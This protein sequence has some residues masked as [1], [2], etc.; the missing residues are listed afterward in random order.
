[1][2]D[3][4]CFLNIGRIYP[5][6]DGR[7]RHWGRDVL[8]M[9]RSQNNTRTLTTISSKRERQNDSEVPIRY[10]AQIQTE[11]ECFR[12]RNSY[13]PKVPPSQT[14]HGGGLLSRWT[15]AK[16]KLRHKINSISLA[17][18]LKRQIKLVFR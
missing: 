9:I 8:G 10:R 11:S 17:M 16:M 12:R 7:S 18:K 6:I 1:M 2:I 5:P 13:H 4:R 14:P 15:G 3:R